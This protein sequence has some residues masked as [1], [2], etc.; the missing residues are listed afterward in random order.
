MPV[1]KR[2]AAVAVAP[3]ARPQRPS[4]GVT[5]VSPAVKPSVI[6]RPRPPRPPTRTR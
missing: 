1:V 4:Y 6:Q 2:K 5:H 3:P